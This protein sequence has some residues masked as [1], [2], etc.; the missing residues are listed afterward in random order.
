MSFIKATSRGHE[1]VPAYDV[2]YAQIARAFEQFLADESPHCLLEPKDA[3]KTEVHTWDDY[4]RV[5]VDRYLGD[6]DLIRRLKKTAVEQ[7]VD[8][9]P[10]WR[11]SQT[12]FDED[13]ASETHAA[14]KSYLDAYIAKLRRL[15][16]G[17]FMAIIDSPINSTFVE[18]LLQYLPHDFDM[19]AKL[20]RISAFLQSQHFA[21]VPYIWI[22]G[23]MYACL[24]DLVK[25]GAYTKRDKA[26]QRLSGLFHD[27][28][29]IATYAPYCDAFIM[30]QPM[31]ELTTHPQLAL[32]QRY[33]VKVF[34]LQNWDDLLAWLDEIERSVSVEHQAALRA[35]YP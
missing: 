28:K 15:A 7:L 31:A 26:L 10:R 20:E 24:K 35:V 3:V 11:V 21:Q 16:T 9:F 2:E 13:I 23:R 27:V 33:D 29:H 22:S 1:F 25:N 8:F 14:G 19:L 18:R 4:F 5:D 34:S 12:T 30:D 6:I 32:H 17:D